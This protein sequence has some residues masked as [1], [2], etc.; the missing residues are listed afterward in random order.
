MVVFCDGNSRGG[1]YSL[2]P[3]L[4]GRLRIGDYDKV[5]IVDPIFGKALAGNREK[6][7]DRISIFCHTDFK[8][9]IITESGGGACYDVAIDR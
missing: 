4:L 8:E 1:S 3:F 7:V 9:W 6:V 2:L 5:M